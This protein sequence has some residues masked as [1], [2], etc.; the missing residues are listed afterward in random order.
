MKNKTNY[1][2]IACFLLALSVQSAGAKQDQPPVSLQDGETL[3]FECASSR[4]SLSNEVSDGVTHGE[5]V[6]GNMPESTLTP[7]PATAIPPSPSATPSSSAFQP[8]EVWHAPG[9]HLM[10]DGAMSNPHEHGD[11]PPKWAEDFSEE[12]FGHP[13]YYGGDE[14]SSDTENTMKHQSFKGA[15]MRLNTGSSCAVDVYFR[16]HAASNPMDR[17]AAFHSYEL[18]MKDCKGGVSFRQGLYWVGYPE[19]RSQRMDR[20]NEQPDTILPAGVFNAQGGKS[21]PGRD[22]FILSSPDRRD[23]FGLDGILQ[24]RCEQWYAFAGA[25]GGEFS[26]TICNATTRFKYDEYLTDYH[27]MS[28]WDLTGATGLGRRFEISLYGINSSVPTDQPYGWFCK[29]KIADEDKVEGA[30]HRP[31][32]DVITDGVNSPADCLAGYLPQYTAPTFPKTGIY[33]RINNTQD[34]K[35]YPGA[36]IVTVPN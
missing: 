25:F 17:V 36:G 15:L 3:Q 20:Y 13:I 2:L 16:Y 14:R 35:T 4:V 12:N 7:E 30:T 8:W 24:T 5:V 26:I 23:W 22:Q 28:T 27:D 18:Y 34:L 31:E 1:I 9:S 21:A 29:K 19:F 6:C 33:F 11:K 32:W 10:P